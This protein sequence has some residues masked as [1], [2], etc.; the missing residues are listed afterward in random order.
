MG[1]HPEPAFQRAQL[2]K[3]YLSQPTCHTELTADQTV[4]LHYYIEHGEVY[5]NDELGALL[6]HNPYRTSANAPQVQHIHSQTK[7]PNSP[8]NTQQSYWPI[9]PKATPAQTGN[10]QSFMQRTPITNFTKPAPINPKL[11]STDSA[12]IPPKTKH[13]PLNMGMGEHRITPTKNTSRSRMAS[14]K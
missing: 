8:V 9:E 6:Q 4:L 3:H 1:H 14:L 5:F 2:D 11:L 7:L 13:Q 12:F 10:W